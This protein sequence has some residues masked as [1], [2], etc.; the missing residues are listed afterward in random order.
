MTTRQAL[1]DMIDRIPDD[2]LPEAEQ[3]LAELADYRA[4]APEDAPLEDEPLTERELEALRDAGRGESDAR[5][6][7][8]EEVERLLDGASA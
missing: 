1:K 2:S 3:R 5:S 6:Y 4:Y 8:R 7:T